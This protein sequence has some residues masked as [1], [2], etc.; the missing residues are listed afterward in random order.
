[1]NSKIITFSLVAFVAIF[2]VAIPMDSVFAQTF[3]AI[4]DGEG[5]DHEGK[6]CPSKERKGASFTPN[7]IS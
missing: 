6:S 1:M 2:S 3:D 4:P 7:I 5:G